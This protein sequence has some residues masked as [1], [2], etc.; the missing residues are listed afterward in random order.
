MSYIMDCDH[1]LGELMSCIMDC[2]YS[3]GQK[4]T[5]KFVYCFMILFL[6]LCTF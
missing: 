4:D 2:D 6:T 1:S 5:L 3:L